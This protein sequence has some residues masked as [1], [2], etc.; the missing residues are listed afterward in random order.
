MMEPGAKV[1]ITRDVRDVAQ[2]ADGQIGVYEGDFPASI[3]LKIDGEIREYDYVDFMEWNAGQPY[4]IPSI[5]EAIESGIPNWKERPYYVPNDNP[6]IRLE[7]GSHIW[8][9]ECWWGPAEGAPPLEAAQA[10]TD[11]WLGALL[12]LLKKEG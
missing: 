8:G 4:P 10:E 3:L 2:K 12:S 11:A 7:D 9:Y 6:R 1:L 5:R